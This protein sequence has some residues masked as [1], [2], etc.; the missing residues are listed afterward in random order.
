MNLVANA[1]MLHYVADPAN[2][3]ENLAADGYPVT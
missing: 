1:I 2:I 3:P